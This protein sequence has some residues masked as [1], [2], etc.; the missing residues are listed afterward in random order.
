MLKRRKI[1]KN[2]KRIN[3]KKEGQSRKR[4]KNKN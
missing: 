2:N 3:V 4:K 1:E